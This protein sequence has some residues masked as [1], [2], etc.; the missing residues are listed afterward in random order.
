MVMLLESPVPSG[1]VLSLLT[2]M[3]AAYSVPVDTKRVRVDFCSMDRMPSI[4]EEKPPPVTLTPVTA[5]V[6]RSAINMESLRGNLESAVAS[7]LP[8]YSH[9]DPNL[10]IAQ[11]VGVSHTATASNPTVWLFMLRLM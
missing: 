10:I 6:K 2:L 9:P 7:A 8:Q 11:E 4:T 3:D 5:A 1:C